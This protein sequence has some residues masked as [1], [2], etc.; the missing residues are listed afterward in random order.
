MLLDMDTG[1]RWI[2]KPIR[3]LSI[4]GQRKSK[5]GGL[6]QPDSNRNTA[7]QRSFTRLQYLEVQFDV[8]E[9]PENDCEKYR[10]LPNYCCLTPARMTELENWIR[11]TEILLWAYKVKIVLNKWCPSTYEVSH[12]ESRRA[13]WLENTA[14]RT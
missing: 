3:P 9:T 12:E 7:W 2:L 4:Q 14:K 5:W 13:P 10:T 11:E 6:P 1:W 8:G